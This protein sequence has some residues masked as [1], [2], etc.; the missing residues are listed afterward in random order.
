MPWAPPSEAGPAAGFTTGEPWLPTVQ[1][2]EALNV[3]TQAAD[4]R[5]ALSLTRRLAALRAARPALQGGTQHTIDAAPGVL[6]WERVHD[7]EHVLAAVNFGSAPAPVRRGE[8]LVSTDPD[9]APG[10]VG[11]LAA[12]EGVLLRI[13]P[14]H[15]D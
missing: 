12:G 9:R 3:S 7:D 11:E 10:E 6:A 1:D 4:P 14:R 15:A 2:A 5:S 13:L 8:L